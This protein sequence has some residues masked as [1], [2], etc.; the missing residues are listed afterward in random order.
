MIFCKGRSPRT[1]TQEEEEGR[2]KSYHLA[3]SHRPGRRSLL[4]TSLRAAKDKGGRPK[5]TETDEKFSNTSRI[6]AQT[7]QEGI[8]EA[9]HLARRS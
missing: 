5:K 6:S 3:V 9:E 2:R 7:Q 4:R 1:Q 8:E